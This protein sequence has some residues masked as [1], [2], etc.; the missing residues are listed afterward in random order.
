[1]TAPAF[2]F[3]RGE[4]STYLVSGHLVFGTVRE[5][6]NQSAQVFESSGEL[7]FDLSQVTQS[8]SAGLALLIEWYRLAQSHQRPL[9]FRS[10]P[11]QLQALAKIS[12]LDTLLP[13]A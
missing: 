13:F 11:P 12:D 8:D 7:Q 4:G 3:K 9:R 5:V 1:M 2:E 6:L 10:V